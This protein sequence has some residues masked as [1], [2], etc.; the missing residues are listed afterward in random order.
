MEVALAGAPGGRFREK[1]LTFVPEIIAVGLARRL[2]LATGGNSA[3]LQIGLG[4]EITR[5]R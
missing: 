1:T 5:M 4:V 2:H 3:A